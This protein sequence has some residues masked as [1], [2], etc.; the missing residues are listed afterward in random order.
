[1]IPAIRDAIEAWH[2][3]LTP[4]MAQESGHWLAERQRELGL[5]FGTRPVCTALRPRFL[6]PAQERRIREVARP[7][8]SAFETTW[9]AALADPALRAQFMLEP[10]EETL[11]A[12]APRLPLG[13]PL[14]RL[15]AFFAPDGEGLRFTE[16]N[17]ETPAG[18]GYS[19]ALAPMFERIPVMA[20]FRK[21]WVARPLH[22]VPATLTALVEY[23]HQWFGTRATPSIAILDW[24][25]VPTRS[26][27]HLMERHLQA[28]GLPCLVAD[29]READYRDGRLTVRGTPVTLVYKRVLI[30]ELVHR[31][32]LESPLVRATRDGAVCLVDPFHCKP[33]HKKAS[34]A[35]LSD[36][37]NAH[38]FSATELAAIH[39]H[40]PWTRRVERR[41]TTHGGATVD[42]L[43]F[44]ER[45]KDRLVL[46]PNDEYG[47]TGIVLGWE[48]DGDAWRSAL[49]HALEAPYV[50]Q[51]R[52]HI[53][54]EPYP[55]LD[56]EGRLE[57]GPRTVDTAPYCYGTWSEGILSRVS[58]ASL[59][60]VTAGGGSTVPTFL[61][62][63]R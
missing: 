9:R 5:V 20:P 4:A 54:S 10:W 2:A 8:L 18:A 17:A 3:L 53:P 33:L 12:D 63:P 45:E 55:A 43:E 16:Y 25:D 11:L 58:T 44:C 15:D 52:I 50:V 14:G 13:S 60:N 34:L 40:I 21:H 19:D 28:M 61:V 51:E 32:G 56:A 24:D 29:P 49:T 41:A 36:E 1:M 46:K 38:L 30:H 22:T 23:H 37:R 6:T 48:C 35:V 59:V 31:L 62:E 27:H 57:I 7:V 47:G 39:A 26:E 42:L